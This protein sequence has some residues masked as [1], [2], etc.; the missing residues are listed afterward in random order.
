MKI[1]HSLLLAGMGLTVL[2]SQVSA[3]DYFVQ[4]LRPGPVA[5]TALSAISLQAAAGD[6]AAEEANA[7]PEDDLTQPTGGA[8]PAAAPAPTAAPAAAPATKSTSLSVAPASP[9]WVKARKSGETSTT[10]TV[11]TTTTSDTTT[12][13]PATTTTSAPAT[14][15]TTTTA[16]ATTTTTAPAPTT[17]STTTST[18]APASL[19]GPAPTISAA[20]T[21]K[22]FD[23]LMNSG[24]V[25]GGDRIFLLDG[26]HGAMTVTGK[27]FTAPVLVTAMPGQVAHVDSI[28]V[29]SSSK[30]VFRGL[31][32]WTSANANGLVS[33]VRSYNDTSDLVFADL[34]VRSNANATNYRQWTVTDWNN[35]QRSGLLIDGPR[36][37][38]SRNRVTGIFNGIIGMGR[39]ILIE[40]NIVD[41]FSGDGMRALADN[42]IVRR[43]KVQNCHQTSAS[44]IDAFQSWTT[45]PGG[46]G[47]GTLKNF[48][49]EDNKM[50]EY[51]GTRNAI[52]CK[53]Q[54]I[55][56]FA[57]AYDGFVIRNNLVSTSAYHGIAIAAGINSKIVNNT[58]IHAKGQ[59]GNFPWIRVSTNRDGRPSS[60]M[61]VANN[62]ATAVKA[63]NDPTMKIAVSNN[64]VVTNA[65]N[66]F[67]SLTN[68][69]FTLKSTSKAVDAGAAALAPADDIVGALRPKGK[70]PDAGA[71]ENF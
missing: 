71:Y 69:D 58:V 52:P 39:D 16:P 57:G 32:V 64:I 5:G 23:L 37:T 68:Q 14:T 59:A 48:L 13:A 62:M 45:G 18:V 54:G 9:K 3:A 15:T 70:A 22:S 7:L 6:S 27:K 55:S 49:I 21:F 24:K 67:T 28:I 4:P 63:T 31:K 51:V 10:T 65:A 34:D 17:T 47:T 2:G 46:V 11:S 8:A 44:H 20:Q 41:G 30:M 36:Q 50:L 29:R 1:V 25:Q 53:L 19:S 42:A 40:E 26:Y 38:V 66:E 12:T 60:N 33:L 56:L 43:N 61:V 35:N